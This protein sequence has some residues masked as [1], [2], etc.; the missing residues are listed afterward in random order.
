MLTGHQA[1]ALTDPEQLQRHLLAGPQISE[2][3]DRSVPPTLLESDQDE[4]MLAGE[5]AKTVGTNL[6]H[7]PMQIWPL[8]A[9]G[10]DRGVPSVA[11]TF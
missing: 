2:R 1:L 8:G 5:H 9:R 10:G 4:D 6:T 7:M 11:G 3:Y